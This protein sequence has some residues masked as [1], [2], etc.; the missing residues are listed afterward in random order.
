MTD[1]PNP[2]FFALT[3]SFWLGVGAI[4]L[5]SKVI[6]GTFPDYTR[7]IPTQNR[8]HMT[9]GAKVLSDAVARVALV[10]GEKARAVK[11]SLSSDSCVLSVAGSDGNAAT[12][13]IT[14]AYDGEPL[15]VGFNAKYVSEIMA[16]AEGGE[17]TVEL[18]GAGD[19]ALFRFAEDDGMIA[20]CMPLRVV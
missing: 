19:P 9:V 18:G 6:D 10:S 4:A 12:E 20:V 3:E 14:V 17:V 15:K 2:V 7:V 1:K 5:V 11:L 13:E 8:N 16:Q